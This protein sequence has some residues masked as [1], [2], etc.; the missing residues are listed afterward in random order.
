METAFV[1]EVV[2]VPPAVR[3]SGLASELGA[4]KPMLTAP[5]LVPP[6]G[7]PYCGWLKRLNASIRNCA[8]TRSVSLKVF[9]NDESTVRVGGPSQSPMRALPTAPNLK[10]FI[11]Y[12]AGLSHW[13]LLL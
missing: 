10:P 3:N 8:R 9:A 4:L 13:K 12:R 11:V 1:R 5:V 7:L 6:P 2:G